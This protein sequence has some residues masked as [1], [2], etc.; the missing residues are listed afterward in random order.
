MIGRRKPM[1]KASESRIPI[2]I[3]RRKEIAALKRGGENYDS[4]LAKMADQYDPDET[5]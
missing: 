4:L 5:E 2:S 1:P 3:E